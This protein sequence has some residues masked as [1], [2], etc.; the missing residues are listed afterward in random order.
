MASKNIEL[1]VGLLVLIGIAVMIFAIWL[2]KGYRYG[3]EFQTVS[4]LFPEIGSLAA[5]D[6]VMVSGVAKGKVKKIQLV[7]GNV[8]VDFDLA[9]DI[10]LKEDASFVIKNIGLM[11]ERFLAIRTGTSATRLDLSRPTIGALDPGIPEVMGMMGEVIDRLNRMTRSLEKT[12]ISP[13]TLDKFSET[14]SSLQSLSHRFDSLSARNLPQIDRAVSNFSQLSDNLKNGVDR[15]LHHMDTA[16]SNFDTA[17]RRVMGM[18][19]DLEKA[20]SKLRT[21]ADDLDHSEGSLRLFM[22]D[23]RLYDD[24]RTT[25]KRIDS[26]VGDIRANPKKYINFSV[27]LF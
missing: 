24:L 19:D 26:L 11:G 1:K 14:I 16:F 8:R 17:S 21:F 4:V 18:L 10:V 15:N 22:E 6:P 20:S 25:A 7:D 12:A 2:V 9:S 13:N 27:E 5:G 23:R 3:Q